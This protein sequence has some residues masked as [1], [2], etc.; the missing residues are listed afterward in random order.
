M[1]FAAV[2]EREIRDYVP[3]VVFVDEKNAVGQVKV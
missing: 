2:D 1:S 3:R